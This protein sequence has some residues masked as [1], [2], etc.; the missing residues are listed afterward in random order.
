ML[1]ILSAWMYYAFNMKDPYYNKQVSKFYRICSSYYFWTNLMLIL[2]QILQQFNFNGGLV[3]W[4]GGLPFI[5][6]IIIF[7]KKSSIDTLFSSNL[8]FRSGEEL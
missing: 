7:E 5:A 1:F 4:I 2:S 8:K 3:A 6:I